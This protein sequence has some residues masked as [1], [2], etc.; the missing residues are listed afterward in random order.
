MVGR[1]RSASSAAPRRRDGQRAAR[2]G[3]SHEAQHSGG[4][5]EGVADSDEQ[6]GT[7][8]EHDE[9]NTHVIEHAEPARQRNGSL[10]VQLLNLR[11]RAQRRDDE[12]ASAQPEAAA[13]TRRSTAGVKHKGRKSLR[14]NSY[15]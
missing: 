4:E 1:R 5:A 13:A 15:S 7:D 2:G 3:G 9:D 12:V 8:K 10:G 6:Q 11:C 14:P